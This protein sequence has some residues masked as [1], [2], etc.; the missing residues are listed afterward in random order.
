MIKFWFPNLCA[1]YEPQMD[2]NPEGRTYIERYQVHD[3]PHVGIIDPRTG[4]LVWRREGWTQEK[5]MTAEV[6]AEHAMDFCSRNS[7]DRPPVAPRPGSSSVSSARPAKR[8]MHEMTEDEQLQAAMRASMEDVCVESPDEKIR[9]DGDNNNDD[10]DDEMVCVD[11][12]SDDNAND[13]AKPI[14]EEEE[15]EK[16]PPTLIDSLLAVELG[17]EPA[18]GAR[19]QLRM[20]DVGRVVRKFGLNDSVRTVYAYV[21]VSSF[22]AFLFQIWLSTTNCKQL[23]DAL[24]LFFF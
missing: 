17:E 7:F 16:K 19:V 4:R 18:N 22:L 20:P 14:A 5:P 8:P 11:S 15:E 13:G 2:T 9:S 21:A 10:N 23:M 6:F 12:G 24:F 1:R 3:Y